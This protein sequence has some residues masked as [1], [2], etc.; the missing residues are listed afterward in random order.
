MAVQKKKV[1]K[2]DTRAWITILRDL[3]TPAMHCRQ[4]KQSNYFWTSPRK[5]RNENNI[6]TTLFGSLNIK[7]SSRKR[8]FCKTI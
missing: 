4:A 6:F 1:A 2:L 8:I 3:I 5:N 7:E